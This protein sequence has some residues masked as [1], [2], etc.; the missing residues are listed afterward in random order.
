MGRVRGGQCEKFQTRSLLRPNSFR[1]WVTYGSHKVGT[2]QPWVF[3]ERV[4]PFEYFQY[5]SSV[6]CIGRYMGTVGSSVALPR[7]VFCVD[8]R[9]S[10]LIQHLVNLNLI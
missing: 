3:T 2:G 7:V 9:Q 4:D 8:V 6:Y 5:S 1:V 10:A